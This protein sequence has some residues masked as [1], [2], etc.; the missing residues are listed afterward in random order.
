LVYY[1]IRNWNNNIY[2]YDIIWWSTVNFTNR[3]NYNDIYTPWFLTLYS[4]VHYLSFSDFSN[5]SNNVYL[6][7]L[8]DFSIANISNFSNLTGSL[9]FWSIYTSNGD[10]RLVFYSI[11][12]GIF[13]YSFASQTISQMN[14]NAYDGG[15]SSI[16]SGSSIYYFWTNPTWTAPSN[17]LYLYS[18]DTKTTANITNYTNYTGNISVSAFFFNGSLYFLY[19]DMHNGSNNLYLH[20]ISTNQI[21]NITNFSNYTGWITIHWAV[22]TGGDALIVR[23]D[24]ATNSLQLNT[25]VYNILNNQ[26]T[27]VAN[28]P[29]T[30]WRQFYTANTLIAGQNHALW[31]DTNQSLQRNLFDYNYTTNILYNITNYSN[32]AGAINNVTTFTYSGATSFRRSDFSNGSHN[33]YYRDP[34]AHETINITDYRWYTGSIVVLT[35][36][37][38]WWWR[39]I[40]YDDYNNGRNLYQYN[41]LTKELSAISSRNW[42]TGIIQNLNS[43]SN[44]NSYIG[45]LLSRADGSSDVYTY[46]YMKKPIQIQEYLP[47]GFILTG[48]SQSASYNT[49]TNIRSTYVPDYGKTEKI[50]LYWYFTVMGAWNNVVTITECN[51]FYSGSTCTWSYNTLVGNTLTYFSKSGSTTSLHIGSWISYSLNYRWTGSPLTGIVI[52]DTIPSV[53]T[54]LSVSGNGCSLSGNVVY[55]SGLSTTTWIQTIVISGVLWTWSV[56]QII[57]NTWYLITSGYTLTGS[58]SFTISGALICQ[59]GYY[60]S[61]ASCVPYN[62][63]LWVTIGVD[64]PYICGWMISWSFQWSST[65]MYVDLYLSGNTWTI[66]NYHFVPTIVGNNY[67]VPIDYINT[68]SVRYVASGYYTVKYTYYSN[69]LVASGSYIEYISNNCSGVPGLCAFTGSNAVTQYPSTG[70]LCS[71]GQMSGLVIAMPRCAPWVSQSQC[72]FQ[73]RLWNCVWSGQTTGTQ[74]SSS[75]TLTESNPSTSTV[76]GICA[77]TG[78]INIS[79]SSMLPSSAQLCSGWVLSGLGIIYAQAFQAWWYLPQIRSYQCMWS[80]WWVSPSCSVTFNVYQWWSSQVV[81]NPIITKSVSKAVA[82]VNEVISY[83]IT[84]YNPN[85][86]ALTGIV[87]QEYIPSDLTGI[88]SSVT[89]GVY[90]SWVWSLSGILAY[91]TWI[92]QISWYYATAGTKTNSVVL[93]GCSGTGCNSS[94]SH[95]IT[96]CSNFAINSPNCNQCA[97]GYIMTGAGSWQCVACVNGLVPNGTQTVC[98]SPCSINQNLINGTCIDIITGVCMASGI[99][100]ANSLPSVSQL[101]SPWYQQFITQTSTWWVW[102]CLGQWGGASAYNCSLTI[103]WSNSWWW[104]TWNTNTWNTNTWVNTGVLNPMIRLPA[105][106]MYVPQPLPVGPTQESLYATSIAIESVPQESDQ[107]I[108]LIKKTKTLISPIL[109]RVKNRVEENIYVEDYYEAPQNDDEL[110]MWEYLPYYSQ[111]ITNLTQTSVMPKTWVEK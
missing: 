109:T 25:Y 31:Y 90:S 3:T 5:G 111:T 72:N 55:C 94:V 37:T 80:W 48:T 15:W 57:T 11:W 101:C 34:F 76:T 74:C 20:N 105:W 110:V 92:L 22:Q 87:V 4:G 83:L 2:G 82:L 40:R 108:I 97:S 81:Y 77:F 24:R 85:P 13:D 67:W 79:G 91:S 106:G 38:F 63:V 39:M 104:T 88:V 58:A 51:Q 59:T 36:Q 18:M 42:Y 14:T 10:I 98:I 52:T 103:S 7:N 73:Q 78:S 46:Q 56:G 100:N 29:Y 33:L 54:G 12:L 45:S 26:T 16:S 62:T 99:Y 23:T 9:T 8:T 96:S 41:F 49:A 32:Y 21:T 19:A 44:G 1:N 28:H 68:G 47:T 93:S 84:I 35:T 102:N 43:V 89:A 69:G 60:Q 66:P 75:F 30:W 53:L 6:A 65:G 61:G 95:T 27:A 50:V 64:D 107:T 70:A 71:V 17:N 86:V